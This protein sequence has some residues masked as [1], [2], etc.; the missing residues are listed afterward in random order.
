MKVQ[1]SKSRNTVVQKEVFTLKEAAQFL[2][3]S[4]ESLRELTDS[5]Q[6][7]CR[8]IGNEV[9]LLR[10]AL[11]DWL[12]G[13]VSWKEHLIAISGKYADDE[14]LAQIRKD[15]YRRRGRAEAQEKWL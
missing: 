10:D 15:I 9:R 7:P 5:G 3:V 4:E 8:K 11:K 13:E 14:S 6:I 2:R 1:S 12:R